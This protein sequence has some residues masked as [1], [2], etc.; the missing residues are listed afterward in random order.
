M[1]ILQ[2]LAYHAVFRYSQDASRITP[3]VIDSRN[4]RRYKL[5]RCLSCT[6]S[7]ENLESRAESLEFTVLS[8][9]VLGTE[10]SRELCWGVRCD[11]PRKQSLARI[12]IVSTWSP[13]PHAI[14]G[15]RGLGFR[16]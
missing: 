5:F 10:P 9:L 14:K 8:V 6:A 1:D 15:L 12:V 2:S 3:F 13:K 11:P 7:L 4:C 16:V